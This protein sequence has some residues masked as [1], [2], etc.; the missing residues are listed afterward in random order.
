MHPRTSPWTPS[1][2]LRC[3][4]EWGLLR[5]T[6]SCL[7]GRGPL[8]LVIGF[9][10]DELR[11]STRRPDGEASEAVL[12]TSSMERPTICWSHMVSCSLP[13][14]SART[15]HDTTQTLSKYRTMTA[16]SALLRRLA[17]L[18]LRRLR[19]GGL[20]TF[21]PVC[22][23]LASDNSAERPP[24]FELLQWSLKEYFLDCQACLVLG[25][26]FLG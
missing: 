6:G 20:A 10:N 14:R 19:S 17:L 15:W 1:T 25:F 22:I 21:A 4:V 2:L 7:H 26:L 8:L 11:L 23:S 12:W 3:S 24:Y 5:C 18:Y 13:A 16:T 9:P